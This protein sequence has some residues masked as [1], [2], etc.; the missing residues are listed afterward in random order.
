MNVIKYYNKETGEEC[1]KEQIS[2]NQK[3][4]IVI[5]CDI[6][7]DIVDA[8][9]R[10]FLKNIKTNKG[11][12]KCRNVQKHRDIYLDSIEDDIK[13]KC[14]YFM[15]KN[16]RQPSIKDAKSGNFVEYYKLRELAN[17]KH[18]SITQYCADINWFYS[19]PD[20]RY[21]NTYLD[22]YKKLFN[23]YKHL[24]NYSYVCREKYKERN[25]PELRWMIQHSNDKNV[26]DNNSFFESLGYGVDNISKENSI[27]II[28][29][30][31][32]TLN[33][34]LRYEDFLNPTIE[35][36]GIGVINKYWGTLNN[37]KKE[38]GL[39]IIQENMLCKQT[40][41]KHVK[42]YVLNV[43]NEV[44]KKEHRKLITSN[45][46]QLYGKECLSNATI[47]KYL[48]KENLILS[49]YVKSLGFDFVKE[50]SG[51]NYTF[52]DGEKCLSQFEKLFSS[53]LRE[54]GLIYNQDYFR[55]VRYNTFIAD[56]NDLMD[57]D[58][59][60]RYNDKI[61]YIEIAGIIAD[62]KKGYYE[63]KIFSSKSKEGYKKKLKEKEQLLKDNNLKYFILFPCDLTKEIL[64]KIL[65]ED[66]EVTK[67]YIA[68]NNVHN[69][70]WVKIREQ[71]EL[72]YIIDNKG[73]KKVYYKSK[74]DNNDED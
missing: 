41:V 51:L 50:G 65:E 59:I 25:L 22:E 72:K 37:M 39:E 63:N 57:C 64:Y 10:S 31:Q 67:Q 13:S 28:Y 73:K 20:E 14:E 45:D 44:Y 3:Y 26:F 62:M 2:T 12:Y 56:Y 38:L 5:Q 52:E 19:E 55:S 40:T 18:L 4:R 48:K 1:L 69:I 21:Y 47:R 34:P 17:R 66:Y 46:F 42:E 43:C 9:Y 68:N 32:K 70:N 27:K 74:G 36:V 6:C 16:K 53:Y 15:I 54:L 58:Y 61:Y 60:I 71:G 49:D 35:T 7:K 24:N 30:M 29:R 23:E 33:R 11:I 8:S